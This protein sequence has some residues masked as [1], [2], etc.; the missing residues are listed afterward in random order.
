MFH[1]MIISMKLPQPNF[2]LCLSEKAK[3]SRL[4]LVLVAFSIYVLGL[5][6]VKWLDY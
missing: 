1:L 4:K 5:N 3:Q 2:L 6:V